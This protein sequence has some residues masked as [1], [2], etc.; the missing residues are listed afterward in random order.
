M[1]SF[2]PGDDAQESTS[3]RRLSGRD[4]RR[5]GSPRRRGGESK[6]GRGPSGAPVELSYGAYDS[7]PA[8]I[9]YKTK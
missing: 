5:R 7:P 3:D 4:A 8:R 1:H 2:A 9:A 6:A